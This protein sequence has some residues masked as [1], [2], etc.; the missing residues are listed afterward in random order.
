MCPSTVRRIV[1]LQIAQNQLSCRRQRHFHTICELSTVRRNDDVNNALW[2]I[3]C[4]QCDRTT[5]HL[6]L[7]CGLICC[8]TTHK[9]QS[10]STFPPIK[11]LALR[12]GVS[13]NSNNFTLR[14]LATARAVVHGQR[15]L[16]LATIIS[17]PRRIKLQIASCR[18]CRSQGCNGLST[19][20]HLQ[21]PTVEHLSLGRCNSTFRQ[22]TAASSPQNHLLL[23]SSRSSV[24]AKIDLAVGTVVRRIILVLPKN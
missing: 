18:L 9:F 16:G 8:C 11:H 2:Y 10:I 19:P 3:R 14:I 22:S 1:Q 24:A 21:R 7:S 4:R 6:E 17:F 5:G 23:L 20:P 13:G 15:I 12:R